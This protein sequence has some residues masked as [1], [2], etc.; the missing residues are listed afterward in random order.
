MMTW[1]HDDMMT[2]FQEHMLIIIETQLSHFKSILNSKL[3]VSDLLTRVKSRDASASKKQKKEKAK[4]KREQKRDGCERQKWRPRALL[5]TALTPPLGGSSTSH[6]SLLII[7]ALKT[8]FPLKR[9]RLHRFF[10][11][12]VKLH[13]MNCFRN[14]F[15]NSVLHDGDTIKND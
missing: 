3:W 14:L 1:W 8:L 6:L 2:R 15:P 10:R 7:I 13:K 11:L 5:S 4:E 9:Q 12:Q